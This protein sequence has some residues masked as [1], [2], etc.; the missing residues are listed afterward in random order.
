M[1]DGNKPTT[2]Q[3]VMYLLENRKNIF[4]GL[5]SKEERM[6]SAFKWCLG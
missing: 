6:K 5:R 3:G 1:L 2:N 4:N